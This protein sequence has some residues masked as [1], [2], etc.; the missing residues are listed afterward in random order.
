MKQI[1]ATEKITSNIFYSEMMPQI[2]DV[3]KNTEIGEDIIM[4][5]SPTKSVDAMAIPLLLNT[6]RWIISCKKTIPQIYI[7]DWEEKDS[8]KNYLEKVGFFNACDFYEYYEV[9]REKI[10]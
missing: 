9:N 10:C 4:D 1:I 2:L 5:L 6:A 3:L 8:L 7:P